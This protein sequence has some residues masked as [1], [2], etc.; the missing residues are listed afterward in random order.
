MAGEVVWRNEFCSHLIIKRDNPHDKKNGEIKDN[1]AKYIQQC[2]GGGRQGTINADE[3]EHAACGTEKTGEGEEESGWQLS[4]WVGRQ[5]AQK[6][7]APGSGRA[8]GKG[9]CV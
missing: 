5:R 4:V 9:I 8:L 3:D 7:G 6:K 1:C 2:L